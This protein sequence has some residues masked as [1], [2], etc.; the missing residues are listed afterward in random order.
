[1]RCARHVVPPIETKTF[2]GG[3]GVVAAHA[4]GLGASVR[5]FTVV[6]ADEGAAFAYRF[7]QDQGIS[8]HAF[9]DDTRPTIR[10]QRYRA[11]GK[12]MLRVNHLRQHPI[13]Q[14]LSR[15]ML[16]QIEDQL[17]HTDLALFSDFNY[18]CLPQPLVEAIAER[19]AARKILMAADSQASSQMA[20]ISRFKDMGLIMPTEREARLALRDAN[21]GLA[22][23]A[24]DLTAASRAQ[25]VVITLGSEGLLVYAKKG[26][27]YLMDRLPA[28]NTAPKDVAGAGDSMFATTSLALCTGTDIWRSVYLGALAAS[29]QVGRVGNAPLNM[30]DLLEQIDSGNNSQRAAGNRASHVAYAARETILQ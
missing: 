2:V 13:S 9:T 24:A 27:D 29:C 8:V 14:T 10:K 17:P 26:D 16:S 21:S 25:A 12:T 11:S 19:A 30:R 20:D 1:M 28:F 23:I 15:K 18:G 5:F 6:G 22:V 3:A 7:L 4:R